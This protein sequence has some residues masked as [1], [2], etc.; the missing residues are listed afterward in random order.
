MCGALG[1]T[2]DG[3]LSDMIIEAF[4]NVHHLICL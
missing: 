4:P 3:E 2:N 1:L